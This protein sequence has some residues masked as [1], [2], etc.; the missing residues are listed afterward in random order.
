[1]EDR[2]REGLPQSVLDL[3]INRIRASVR[4]LEARL[5]RNEWLVDGG[6]TL[7]DICTF[8]IVNN[9]PAGVPD[10]VNEEATPGMMRGAANPN[11][12]RRRADG[13]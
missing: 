9:L 5:S 11:P 13:A 4:Q 7:A 6:Y 2:A 12:P 3:E 10:I 8:A 1:M